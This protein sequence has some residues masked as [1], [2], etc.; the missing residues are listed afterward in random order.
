MIVMVTEKGEPC[1]AHSP[2]HSTLPRIPRALATLTVVRHHSSAY[3]MC[4][5]NIGPVDPM[6]TDAVVLL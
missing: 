3:I 4:Y 6:G 2:V 5:L 1:Q